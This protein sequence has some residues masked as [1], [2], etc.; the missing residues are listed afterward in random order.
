MD[1]YK[2]FE[3]SFLNYEIKYK[4]KHWKKFDFRSKLFKEQYLSNFRNNS[5][6]DGLDD[7]Y[8]F[9]TQKKIFIDLIKIVGENFVVENL[10]SKNIGNSKY[11]FNHKDKVVD[12]GQNFHIMWLYEIDKIINSQKKIKTVCEIG[13]G[14]GSLAQKIIRKYNCKYVSFDL[15]EA[16]LLSSYYLKNHFPEKK[17]YW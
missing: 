17:I 13:G 1:I 14:Y 8:D 15:P 10:S 16:N 2:N 4:S 12:A 11:C 6:S 9:K 5:L 7:R 3:N